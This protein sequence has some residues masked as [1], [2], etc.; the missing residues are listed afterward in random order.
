MNTTLLPPPPGG[1]QDKGPA[2]LAVA[3]AFTIS[4]LLFVLPRVYVRIW[5]NNAF[6]WDD[7]MVIV[8]MVRR[9]ISARL[10]ILIASRFSLLLTPVSWCPPYCSA[11]VS[12]C[13]TYR[14]TT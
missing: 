13:I 3:L 8:A 14:M 4:A 5:M 1:P 9:R 12:I 2:L 7:V 11:M 6:G 10:L